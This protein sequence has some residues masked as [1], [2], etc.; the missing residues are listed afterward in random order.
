MRRIARIH[1]C[2]LAAVL[3]SACVDGGDSLLTSPRVPAAAHLAAGPVERPYG[4]SCS[5]T[6][7]FL[8]PTRLQMEYTCQL[9][10]LGRTTA[11]ATQDL[12]FGPGGIVITNSTVYTAANGD[13][14]H[15]RF[16]GTGTMQP[17]SP[18]V[19]AFT[20]TETYSGGT[21]RFAKAA[22]SAVLTGTATI[23]G[24]GGAGAFTVDGQFTY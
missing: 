21:G 20:G 17:G 11:V 3:T 1:P 15:A 24:T 16:A 5:T 18:G 4:G 22:G 14:L 13:M 23:S 10:H 7:T 6:F 9:R 8:S 2:L 19:V 12:S